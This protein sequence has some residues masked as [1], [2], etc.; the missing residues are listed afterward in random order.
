MSAL[1]LAGI[2]KIVGAERHPTEHIG[3]AVS[4]EQQLFI[5][6]S[7]ECVESLAMRTSDLRQCP[8]SLAL[9]DGLNAEEW[10][11]SQDAAV[12]LALTDEGRVVPDGQ[13]GGVA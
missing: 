8:F 5:L 11:D 3:R 12:H 2:E 6:H 4:E 10:A 13:A 7:V 1:V 9:D